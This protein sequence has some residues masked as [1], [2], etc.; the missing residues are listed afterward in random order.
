MTVVYQSEYISFPAGSGTLSSHLTDLSIYSIILV[1]QY[2]ATVIVRPYSM[3]YN[4]TQ[5]DTTRRRIIDVSAK[6]FKEHGIDATG[7]AAIMSEAN[8]TNGAFYAHFDSKEALIE[9]VIKDQLHTQLA[10]FRQAPKDING[11]RQIIDVYLSNE[12][13]DN[14]S[15]GCPSA[16]LLDEITK[17][18]PSTKQ[19]YNTGII[20][21]I[22][23]LEIS[24][25]RSGTLESKQLIISLLGLLIGTM[26]LARAVTEKELSERIL[27]SGRTAAHTLLEKA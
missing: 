12:H 20:E 5:K 7:V 16:A 25:P 24:L 9:E 2:Y 11:L 13:R 26:Q 27:F 19:V 8:L 6:L 15:G 4:P 14:C 23:G 17:R 22:D 21:I 18:T 3:R 1:I 10:L